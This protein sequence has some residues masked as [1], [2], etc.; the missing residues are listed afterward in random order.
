MRRIG[1]AL[2]AAAACVNVAAG[3]A[4]ALGDPRR[5]GDLQ[6]MWDWCRAWLVDGQSLYTGPEASADYPPNAIVML[7]PLALVAAR[8]LVPLWTT[9]AVALTPVLPWLVL[10]VATPRRGRA[11]PAIA[12]PALLFLCWA[13]PRTLLQ[14]SLFSMVLACAAL[15]LA[16]TRRVAAGVALG[17]AL[18]KPHIAGPVALWMVITGRATSLIVATAVIAAGWTVY[19]V[20]IGEGPLT[21]AAG[22]WRVIGSEYSGVHGLVGHM[23]IRGWTRMAVADVATADA[24]WIALSAGLLLLVCALAWRGR[25]RAL[26]AGGIAIPAMFSLCSLLVTYHNGNNMI[27][28][29]PAFVF[30]WFHGDRRDPF[31]YWIPIGI[32]QAA[33]MFDVPVRLG[34]VPP[35]VGWGRVAIEQFDRVLVLATL[36]YVSVLWS[37]LATPDAARASQSP[38]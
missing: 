5:A 37:R 17:L 1:F 36:T 34:A 35:H 24:I 7:A 25:S 18:C 6:V 11:L 20:R 10:R 14:F 21:T 19:D 12:V 22:Y 33:L 27:L 15:L 28:M 38:R 3:V 30:L 32:L 13:A 26:D 29:L 16:D 9:L 4:L 31:S 2:L 23:S 8:R